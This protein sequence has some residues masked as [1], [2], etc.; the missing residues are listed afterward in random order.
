[1]ELHNRNV[2]TVKAYGVFVPGKLFQPCVIFVGVI[3]VG[4]RQG[5]YP[6][7]HGVG[8]GRNRLGWKD[9]PGTNTLA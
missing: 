3:F 5:A 2:S 6:K 1:M 9:L 4:V 7:T 8:S